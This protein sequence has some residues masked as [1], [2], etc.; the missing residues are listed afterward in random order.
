MNRQHTLYDS[1][2]RSQ[3][4]YDC[5]TDRSAGRHERDSALPR[6]RA[7]EEQIRASERR[8]GGDERQQA[9]RA[10][11]GITDRSEDAIEQPDQRDERHQR[12]PVPIHEFT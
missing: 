2:I 11:D 12:G 8:Q 3:V 6:R 4:A 7:P 5:R 9:A 10:G 1:V